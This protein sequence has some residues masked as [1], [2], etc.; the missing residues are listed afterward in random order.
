[1]SFKAADTSP[2]KPTFTLK[3]HARF[4]EIACKTCTYISI[5]P[6]DF[7]KSINLNV[8]SACSDVHKGPREQITVLLAC[9]ESVEKSTSSLE[10]YN[11]RL[12]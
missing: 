1:M 2:A 12:F 9:K 5:K 10:T 8:H 11:I 7:P 6:L 3:Y 4:R